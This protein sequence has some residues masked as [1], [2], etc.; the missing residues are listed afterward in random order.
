MKQ[1]IVKLSVLQTGKLLA[2]LYGFISIVMLPFMFI[3]MLANTEEGAGPMLGMLVMLLLYPLMGFIGG[4]VM[5]ALYN[6]AAK[7]MGGLEFC[8][9]AVEGEMT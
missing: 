2:V 6:L 1:R 4:I 3:A 9:E 5:A 7:W 8:V